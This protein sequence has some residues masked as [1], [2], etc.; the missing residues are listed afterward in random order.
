MLAL[1]LEQF[2]KRNLSRVFFDI[3]ELTSVMA[4]SNDPRELRYSWRAWR[5]AAGAPLRPLYTRFVELANEAAKL[6]GTTDRKKSS[7]M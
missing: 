7:F 4:T 5:D 1:S 2:P 3:S 6:N